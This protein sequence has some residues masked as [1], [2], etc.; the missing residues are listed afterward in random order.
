M[1]H[2]TRLIKLRKP[3]TLFA[4]AMEL[5]PTP[6]TSVLANTGNASA[7]HPE[8]RKTKRER[9]EVAVMDVLADDRMGIRK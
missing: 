8:R 7:Y 4:L 2:G 1:N 5:A 6:C 9:R 3:I